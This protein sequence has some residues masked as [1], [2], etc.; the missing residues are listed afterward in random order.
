MIST[1]VMAGMDT[2]EMVD[3]VV[4]VEVMAAE[5]MAAVD[6]KGENL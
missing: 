2:A 4:M 5:V 1:S 3:T 6:I